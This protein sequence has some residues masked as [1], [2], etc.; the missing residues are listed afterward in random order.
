MITTWIILKDNKILR[1]CEATTEDE[2]IST[3]KFFGILDYDEIR[4]TNQTNSVM[5]GKDIRE[6]DE[7]YNLRPELDRIIDGLIEAPKGKKLNEAKT[8]LIDKTIKEKIDDGELQLSEYEIYDEDIKDIRQKNNKE[9]C[10]DNVITLG[11]FKNRKLREIYNSFDKELSEG[12][13]KSAVLG[14]DVDCRRE[15]TK[16]DLQNVQGLISYMERNGVETTNYVGYSEV[17]DN[18]TT[19]MLN[20]LIIE[21]EDHVLSLYQ[22]KWA[23]ESQISSASD[24]ETLNNINW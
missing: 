21:M 3:A 2:V 7:N 11:E 20:A 15:G 8:E 24:S 22:K 5:K 16:N 10:N 17:K 23:L 1:S 19:E 6:Y 9:L 13:F 4:N 14:I 18:V 12:F